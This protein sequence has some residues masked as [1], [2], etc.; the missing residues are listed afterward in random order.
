MNFSSAL[1][2]P[3]FIARFL[4]VIISSL[5]ERKLNNVI[6]TGRKDRDEETDRKGS[7]SANKVTRK[8][9]REL[10]FPDELST[11]LMAP[12]V[13]LGVNRRWTSSE[14]HRLWCGRDSRPQS[15]PSPT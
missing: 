4:D 12:R 7:L 2:L 3:R 8:S 15:L 1:P 13:H 14:H 10:T 5:R 11:L 9:R 6:V